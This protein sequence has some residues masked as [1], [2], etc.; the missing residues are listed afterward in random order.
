MEDAQTRL[1]K[2]ALKL[3]NLPADNVRDSI[4]QIASEINSIAKTIAQIGAQPDRCEDAIAEGV[5]DI[6]VEVGIRIMKDEPGKPY[7]QHTFRGAGPGDC[8]PPESGEFE[9]EAWI[10]NVRVWQEDMPSVDLE[11]LAFQVAEGRS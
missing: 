11:A 8:I 10:G 9:W 6:E 4:D 7:I 5:F 3:R 1:R 2:I